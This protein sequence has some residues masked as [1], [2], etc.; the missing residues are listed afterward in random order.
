[1][2]IPVK[3]RALVYI[4]TSFAAPFADENFLFFAVTYIAITAVM[5]PLGQ[6]YDSSGYSW[7]E[8]KLLFGLSLLAWLLGYM[9]KKNKQ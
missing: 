6:V 8:H 2:K 4:A 3:I 9:F 7:N 5:Y 1:M